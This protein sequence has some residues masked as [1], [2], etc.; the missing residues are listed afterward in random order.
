MSDKKIDELSI[1]EFYVTIRAI[2]FYSDIKFLMGYIDDVRY[3]IE[4]F[5]KYESTMSLDEINSDIYMELLNSGDESNW[6]IAFEQLRQ[7]YN[8]RVNE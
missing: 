2:L 4:R 6:I 3:I 8:K 1:K 7:I 5:L